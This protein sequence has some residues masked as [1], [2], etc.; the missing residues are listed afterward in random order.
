M[1][2]LILDDMLKNGPKPEGEGQWA[3]RERGSAAV[4]AGADKLREVVISQGW[5]HHY[6]LCYGDIVQ[7]LLDICRILDIEP[8]VVQ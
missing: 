4:L 2:E 7:E 8:V 3:S 5:E 6:A 1:D